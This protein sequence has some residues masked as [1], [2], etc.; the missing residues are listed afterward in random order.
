MNPVLSVEQM[1]AVDNGAIGDDTIVGYFY[2][3][4]AGMGL[5]RHI[6]SMFPDS[7]RA[8]EIAVVCGKGN[9]GGDGFVVARLLLQEG[10]TVMCFTM[11]SPE[12]LTGECR[13]AC[14][15][16][17]SRKGT[18]LTID[19]IA[20]FPH[21]SRFSLVVDALLG[22]GIHGDPRGLYAAIIDIINTSGVAVLSADT[23]SGLD[24]NTGAPAKSCIRATATV[25]MGFAKPGLYFHPGRSMVGTLHIEDLGYPEEIVLKTGPHLFT[26]TVSYLFKLLPPRK[27]S[28]TKHDHGRLLIAGGSPGMTGSISM[29]ARAALR[30][31]CGMVHCAFPESLMTI[32]SVKLTEPVLH[33]L[34]QTSL[35]TASNEAAEEIIR[36]TTPLQA[37]CLG[38]GISTA[39]ETSV[40][41]RNVI[42]SCTVPTVLD[43]DG[44][45]AYRGMP[46]TL[47]NHAS[48]LCITPHRGE[49]ERLFGPLPVAPIDVIETVRSKAVE[50]NI[51]VLLKG[52]PTI[53]AGSNGNVLLLPYGN[54]SLAKAGSGDILS[55][56]IT[57]LAAQGA[58]L[59]DAAVVGA[60]LHG[61]AGE[62]ASAKLNEYSV[63]ADDL[64][65]AIAP[66]ISGLVDM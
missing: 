64:I 15:E 62:I 42:R 63:T 57:A 25:A 16:F 29:T 30:S 48:S 41:V 45:N 26:P 9:N 66:A 23:P 6:R 56:I 21:P 40:M 52:N 4:K 7:S 61:T 28:G 20:D 10:Y 60:Y 13:I 35:Q 37:L 43:A 14:R 12:S 8:G 2:M 49:W 24:N 58:A 46:S 22:T 38:P 39:E 59:F 1:R 19:D 54:S 55:G 31:G 44:I 36:L 5:L 50:Y 51:T 65:N 47:A 18:L 17:I 11:A 33:P 32:L 3:Q 27:Q 34:P 53:V